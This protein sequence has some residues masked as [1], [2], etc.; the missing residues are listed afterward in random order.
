MD[1]KFCFDSEVYLVPLYGS[2][3]EPTTTE[4]LKVLGQFTPTN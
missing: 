3:H 2:F 4:T 1:L